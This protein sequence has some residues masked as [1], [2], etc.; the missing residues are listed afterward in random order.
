MTIS[1]RLTDSNR[2]IARKVNA[3]LAEQLNK[4][5]R[6]KK[7]RITSEIKDAMPRW[8]GS[9]PEMQEIASDPTPGSLAAQLGIERGSGGEAARAIIRAFVDSME[10]SIKDVNKNTLAGGLTINFMPSTF[11][12]L[13]AL[14]EGHTIYE[15]G[16]LHW[17]QWML[18]E[19]YSTIVVGFSYQYSAGG[20]SGGGTMKAPGSWRIPPQYA[21]TQDNNF[22]T[23]ALTSNIAQQEIQQIIARNIK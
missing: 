8:L 18:F 13:L 20:R 9:Q 22:I 15:G 4:L 23:R 12:S 3:I 1:I 7:Q 11:S 14:P 5:F 16:D 17:L 6:T 10:V 19:G 21:G 2:S